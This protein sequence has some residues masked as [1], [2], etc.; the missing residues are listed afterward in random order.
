MQPKTKRHSATQKTASA[1]RS[2]LRRAESTGAVIVE[3]AVCLPLM[4]LVV[5]GCI[6]ANNAIFRGQALTSVAHEGVIVG[7][8]PNATAQDVED[9]VGVVMAAR[10]ISAYTV[11][12]ETFGVDFDD[13]RSGELFRVEVSSIVNN[14]YITAQTI[15]ASVTAMHP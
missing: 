11:N 14:D 15:S 3:M 1:T 13:L 4:L 5:F 10:G 8:K 2:N 6:E 9:R 12:V 7:I